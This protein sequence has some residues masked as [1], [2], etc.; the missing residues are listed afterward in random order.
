MRGEKV[1]SYTMKVLKINI[2][3]SPRKINLQT[4]KVYA[5]N[6]LT[7]FSDLIIG[8]KVM[9]ELQFVERLISIRMSNRS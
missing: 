3:P 5:I 4:P 6:I 7:K 2:I 9:G 1:H 8:K